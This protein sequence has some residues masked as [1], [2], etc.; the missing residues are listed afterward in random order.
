MCDELGSQRHEDVGILDFAHHVWGLDRTI[1][2]KILQMKLSLDPEQLYAYRHSLSS[3]EMH[4]PFI[5]ISKSLLK[6][7]SSIPDIPPTSTS[8][9][10]W[11]GEL[12]VGPNLVSFWKEQYPS[13]SGAPSLCAAKHFIELKNEGFAN[14]EPRLSQVDKT[15]PM[16]TFKSCPIRPPTSG[17][18]SSGHRS[19]E[20]RAASGHAHAS[21]DPTL[22]RANAPLG[23]RKH[24]SDSSTS[25]T[26]RPTKR[27]RQSRRA[28]LGDHAIDC[29]AETSRRW[30]A[31]L[32][33]DSFKVTAC[34]FDRHTVACS[35]AFRFDKHPATLALVLYAM[36]ACTKGQAGFDPNL[37]S[38]PPDTTLLPDITDGP[39]LR[40]AQIVGSCFN[41]TPRRADDCGSEGSRRSTTC[42]RCQKADAATRIVSVGEEQE[43][44]HV[45][46]PCDEP[47]TCFRV[48]EFI[49]KPDE[50]ISRATVVYKAH[51]RHSDGEFC[52]E[53]CAL[54]LSWPLKSRTSEID[55]LKRLKSALPSSTHGHLPHIFFSQTWTAEQMRIPFIGLTLSLDR[56]AQQERVLC[57]LAGRYYSDLAFL[58]T[59][60]VLGTVLP[61]SYNSLPVFGLFKYAI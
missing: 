9:T 12:C 14:L 21:V 20:Q 44:E 48:A 55:I 46:C 25:D 35:T 8:G 17:R 56:E 61:R 13:G 5:S 37:F 4:Q 57:A 58:G 6:S 39:D 1:G 51:R 28:R 19:S 7:V 26:G 47:S 53:P 24:E 15:R 27:A 34:Y 16:E 22:L 23:K 3:K 60:S 38:S 2:Q 40:I 29:L 18:G 32:F 43:D 49:R 41:F 50:L 30:M 33:I 36:N 45:H 52:Q 59:L 54:K 11:E 10:V 42:H 31:G